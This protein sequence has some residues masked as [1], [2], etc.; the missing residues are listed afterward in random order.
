[1]IVDGTDSLPRMLW[2]IGRPKYTKFPLKALWTTALTAVLSLTS[3]THKVHA[4]AKDTQ[5]QINR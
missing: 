2:Q 1:M 3:R 4:T 5:V